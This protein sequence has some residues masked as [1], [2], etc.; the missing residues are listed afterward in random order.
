M[1]AKK[2]LGILLVGTMVV[3]MSMS[4]YGEEVASN[5]TV[6][7]V[8]TEATQETVS[9]QEG[10]TTQEV[11]QESLSTIVTL[12]VDEEYNFVVNQDG[13][14]G[15]IEGPNE[16]L[17]ATLTKEGMTLNAATQAILASYPEGTPYTVEIV[18]DDESLAASVTETLK[19]VV[20]EEAFTTQTTEMTEMTGQPQLIMNRFTEAKALG[21]TAGKMHLLEKLAE[22]SSEE[23]NNEEWAQKSVK[24]IMAQIKVNKTVE[25]KENATV[26]VKE[27][28]KEK[29]E[30]K[31]KSGDSKSEKSK[32]KPEKSKG[33]D[34]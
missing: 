18:S 32:E 26:K 6:A 8:T 2:F 19:E 10:V 17:I 3:G 24:E 27:Q 22:S 5:E 14:I 1:K 29:E 33:K 20:K 28:V 21:I 25:N 30:V 12:K 34:K 15:L 13:T 31:D 23:V 11:Q 9:T 7:T 4:S 16:E